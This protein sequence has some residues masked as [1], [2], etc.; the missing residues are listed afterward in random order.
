[1]SAC[2]LYVFFVGAKSKYLQEVVKTVNNNN[3]RSETT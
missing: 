2:R 1:M 3:V